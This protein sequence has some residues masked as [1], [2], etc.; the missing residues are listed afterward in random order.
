MFIHRNEYEKLCDRAKLVDELEKECQRLADMISA[1]VKDCK[2]GVWCK[3]CKF[4]GEDRSIAKNS[5]ITLGLPYSLYIKE[6]A[7]E[8]QYCK[9]H[10]YEICPEF[11]GR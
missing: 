6:C 10:L 2:I 4:L 1:E 3:D 11:K 9:K 5:I 8:V 7:G